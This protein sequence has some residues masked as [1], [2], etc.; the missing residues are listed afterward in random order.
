VTTNYGDRGAPENIA[1]TH[2]TRCVHM[3]LLQFKRLLVPRPPLGM[4]DDEATFGP[5]FDATFFAYALRH[6]VQVAEMCRPFNRDKINRAIATFEQAV[7]DYRNVRNVLAHFD[8][9]ETDERARFAD[10]VAA[11]QDSAY[12]LDYDPVGHV[13]RVGG[14]HLDV[15]GSYFAANQLLATVL[16]VLMPGTFP[17]LEPFL[18]RGPSGGETR[19]V[20]RDAAGGPGRLIQPPGQQ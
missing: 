13:L 19:A 18:T 6:S 17:D 3:L 1:G 2:L 12:F 15:V 11:L 10:V 16:A 5:E 9:Y 7:P 14:L 20:G 4:D 8:A